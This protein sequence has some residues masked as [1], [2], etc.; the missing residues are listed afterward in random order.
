MREIDLNFITRRETLQRCIPKSISF[1]DKMKD[2]AQ[3]ESM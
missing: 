1:V 2:V 3:N